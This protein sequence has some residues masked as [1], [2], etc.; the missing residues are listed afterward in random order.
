MPINKRTIEEK[1]LKQQSR[2]SVKEGAPS[3][4]EGIEGELSIRKIKGKVVLI[5]EK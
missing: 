5:F 1:K 2:I 4:S 3:K